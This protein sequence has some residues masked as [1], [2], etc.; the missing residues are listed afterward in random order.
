M[1]AA[2]IPVP[3]I[4]YRSPTRVVNGWAGILGRMRGSQVRPEAR[5]R[6]DCFGKLT[7]KDEMVMKGLGV[8]FARPSEWREGGW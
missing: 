5:I 4:H 8:S 7:D 1:S 3:D 2:S 6:N